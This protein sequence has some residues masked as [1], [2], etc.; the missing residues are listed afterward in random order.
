MGLSLLNFFIFCKCVFVYILTQWNPH[1][2]I[3]CGHCAL[4][5]PTDGLHCQKKTFNRGERSPPSS[6]G[7][8]GCG[9]CVNIWLSIEQFLSS[10]EHSTHVDSPSLWAPYCSK[11]FWVRASCILFTCLFFIL[12]TK[13]ITG[14]TL[15]PPWLLY[16]SLVYLCIVKHKS[17][18]L[19]AEYFHKTSE[20]MCSART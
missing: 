1:F 18:F 8:V 17:T 13:S 2:S 11:C 12:W 5:A 6:G 15:V 3:Y 20:E 10:T 4:G 16:L 14:T 9:S 19:S 7:A